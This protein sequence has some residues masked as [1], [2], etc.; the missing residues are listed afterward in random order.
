MVIIASG[1]HG[2]VQAFDLSQVVHARVAGM[3]AP[4]MRPGTVGVQM[5]ISSPSQ[6]VREHVRQ[7]FAL[8]HAQWDFEAYRHFCAALAED[9]DCLMAYCGVTLALVQP[10]SEFADQRR[11]AVTR[12]LDMIDADNKAVVEGKGE[13]FSALEK[14]FA[15]AIAALVSMEPKTSGAIF[16]EIAEQYPQFIQGRLISLFLTRGGY[17]VANE[18]SRTRK[19]AIEKTHELMKKYPE[20]PMIIGFWLVLNAEAPS[21]GMDIKTEIL[22][23][24]R[25]L[26]KKCP[27]VPTWQHALG[28]FE[29]RAGNYL[30]AERAFTKAIDLYAEWMKGNEV[31]KNDCEGYMKAKCYLANTLYQ[32]GDFAG[33][34]RVAEEL[35]AMK[36]DPA[37][38]RSVGNHII[39]WRGYSLPARLYSARGADGDLDLALKSLPSKDELDRYVNDPHFPTLAGVYIETLSA[40]IGSRKAIE[41]NAIAEAKILRNITLRSRIGKMA[42][43]VDGA[44]KLSDYTHYFNAGS[45]LA[46]YDMELAGLIALNDEEGSR[47]MASNWFMSAR[48]KQGIPSLMMPPLVLSP[49]E[50]RLGEYYL[51]MGRGVE[52]YEAYQDGLIRYPNNMASLL[53]LKRS[54]DVLGKINESALV[55]RHI[56]LVK[57]RD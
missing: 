21:S 52:A 46:I 22:P 45:S 56:N 9:P 18:P 37:R 13:R 51:K 35:R 5:T 39:L 48:D 32:R 47:M 36:L 30:L 23:H 6:K 3:K 26:V 53:G 54:L 4:K 27:R 14:K 44:M 28:H 8:V 49:M 33:A 16:H 11:A 1:F 17:D 31:T 24:A 29:W 43:V 10:F 2:D 19:L 41:G 34:M 50:N 20:N 12:M 15:M 38:P 25:Y 40:Y 55:Q 42:E 7:G 57:V